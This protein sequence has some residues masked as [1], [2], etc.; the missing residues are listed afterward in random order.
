[1]ELKVG[2]RITVVKI[3]NFRFALPNK[4][5]SDD[6]LELFTLCKGYRYEYIGDDFLIDE[7]MQA[8]QQKKNFSDHIE[9]KCEAIGFIRDAN[10]AGETN[11]IARE[12][13]FL[14]DKLESF[15]RKVKWTT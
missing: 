7:V 2:D 12:S 15:V 9:Y 6:K 4:L 1:M 3:G 14:L 11:F 13:K 8:P 10:V 5:Y